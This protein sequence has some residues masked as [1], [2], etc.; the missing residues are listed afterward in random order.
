[1]NQ[2]KLNIIE[3]IYNVEKYLDRCVQS[4]I[5]QAFRDIE[6]ILVDDESPDICPTVCDEYVII[7]SMVRIIHK[8]G[9]LSIARNEVLSILGKCFNQDVMSMHFLS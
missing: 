4:L 2:E 8:K 1:M 6:I 9:G 3:P 7:D 5:H